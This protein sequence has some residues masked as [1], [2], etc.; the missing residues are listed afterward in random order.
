MPLK[1]HRLVA[2]VL[3]YPAVA[4][5]LDVWYSPHFDRTTQPDLFPLLTHPA[6]AWPRLAN[7]TS[8]FKLKM[9]ALLPS[10]TSADLKALVDTVNAR[11]MRV[12][13]EIGG[14]RWGAGRCNTSSQ[15]LFAKHEQ[16]QA[17]RWT[18]LGGRLDSITTDHACTWDIRHELS[19]EHCD[20]PVPLQARIDAVAQVLASWRQFLSSH[21]N[22]SLGA[23]AKTGSEASIGFIESLGYWD[24]TGPDGTEYRNVDPKK[25][26]NITGWIPRL[27]DMTSLLLAAAARHNPTPDVP[28]I[29]AYQID[30][31]MDGVEQDTLKCVTC[32][33][34]SPTS[35]T[36][37]EHLL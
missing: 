24:I 14:A 30:Y 18:E 7:R 6:T 33:R 32:A 3:L 22:S 27:E 25:L 29:S 4:T 10:V 13:L 5:T 2:S 20:P 34:I 28:L 12:G 31:G 16:A 23:P 37:S 11:G 21:I 19:Q 35:L 17:Q 15:L 9:S 26:G 36:H 1:S 8:T